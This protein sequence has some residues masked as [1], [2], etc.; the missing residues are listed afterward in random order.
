LTQHMI[1]DRVL[2][3]DYPK[4]RFQMQVSNQYW[5]GFFDGQ[6]CIQPNHYVSKIH[7]EKFIVAFRV[8]VVQK[9]PMILYLLQKQFGGYVRVAPIVTATGFKTQRGVW[10]MGRAE[11][12]ISFLSAIKPYVIIK[13]VELSIALDILEGVIQ[14]RANYDHHMK[15]GKSFLSGKKPIE[16]SE[17]KRRQELEKQF[18]K[19]RGSLKSV[20]IEIKPKLDPQT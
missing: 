1:T 20:E 10:E 4:G 14:S 8:S 12:V 11:D 16:L 6:G 3:E 13:A 5:A 19:D 15:D 9:E 18:Y 2:A 17:I 7:G